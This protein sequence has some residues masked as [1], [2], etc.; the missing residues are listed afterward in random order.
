MGEELAYLIRKHKL[1]DDPDMVGALQVMVGEDMF[2]LLHLTMFLCTLEAMCSEEQVRARRFLESC[3]SC[4]RLSGRYFYQLNVHRAFMF[5]SG[6]KTS[7]SFASQE[8]FFLLL[9]KILGA[10]C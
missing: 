7:Q 5:A 1:M 6:D 10:T 4:Q 9:G 2:L 3:I 8:L